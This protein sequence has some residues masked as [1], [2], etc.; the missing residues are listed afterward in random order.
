MKYFLFALLM[1]LSL[2]FSGCSTQK[3]ILQKLTSESTAPYFT[4][5]LVFNPASGKT[6]IDYN[7]GKYFTP[8]STVKLFAL[9]TSLKTLPDSIASISYLD[10]DSIRY[11]KTLADP[12]FLHDSLPNK[13][14][15]FL[16]NTSLK[17]TY[18][19]EKMDDFIYGDGWQWDDFEFYY[20]PEKSIFPIYGNLAELT[21][22]TIV[23]HY[24]QNYLHEVPEPKFHR[25]FDKNIFYKDTTVSGRLR[26]IPFKTSLDLSL[27]LLSD[28]LHKPVFLSEKLIEGAFKPYISTPT[29]PVYKQLMQESE[30]FLAEQLF[31]I[32][33]KEKTGTYKV[34]NTIRY[35]LDSLLQDIPDKPRW[36]D[37]SGLS[38]YNLFTPR[39]MVYLL[40]KL[41]REFGREKVFDL[42][43][44]NGKNGH[45]QKWYPYEKKYLF[46]KTG[47]V[48]N[49]HNLCGYMI[50]KK[51]TFLIFSYMNN[52]YMIESNEVRKNMNR[53]LQQIYNT[54]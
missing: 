24:F 39:S 32:I 48:S 27:R 5:L 41:Y 14:Y 2:L 4:G 36:V 9:Y 22:N 19:P 43:P 10:K 13:T 52:H 3:N 16:N 20:M 8:A 49:N 47:S 23:P 37:A 21:G 30:N 35:A 15:E 45:L 6:V 26:K 50:T 18:I 53:V 40:K 7:S 28:T 31:L 25:D 33:A 42:L 34:K 44:S 51:G 12:S 11:F 1:S 29:Y 54:Y 17:L 38:R 46:A